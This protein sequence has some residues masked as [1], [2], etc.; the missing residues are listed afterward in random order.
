MSCEDFLFRIDN[1]HRVSIDIVILNE[2]KDD[3]PKSPQNVG[4]LLGTGYWVL[5]TGYFFFPSSAMYTISCLKINRFGP[6]SRVT[7]TMFLS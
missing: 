4:T 5:A 3:N 6:S 1:A 2:A 7:R